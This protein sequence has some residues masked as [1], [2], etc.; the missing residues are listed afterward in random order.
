LLGIS[1]QPL[2]LTRMV[3]SVPWMLVAAPN[4][5]ANIGSGLHVRIS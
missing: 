5:R 1:Q 2:R 4:P 3:A